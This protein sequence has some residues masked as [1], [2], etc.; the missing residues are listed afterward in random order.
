MLLRQ[1]F[2]ESV[3]FDG[4]PVR[5]A[6]KN[7]PGPRG[8]GTWESEDEQR[9]AGWPCEKTNAYGV[10]QLASQLVVAVRPHAPEPLW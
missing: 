4:T 9:T 1:G 7:V 5:L 10:A 8:L 6:R 3:C 2:V